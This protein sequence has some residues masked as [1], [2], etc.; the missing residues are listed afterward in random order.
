MLVDV[1]IKL[2]TCPGDTVKYSGTLAGM[3]DADEFA[4]TTAVESIVAHSDNV[5]EIRTCRVWLENGVV[6]S[7]AFVCAVAICV[8]IDLPSLL[9]GCFFQLLILIPMLMKLRCAVGDQP[10]ARFRNAC[11]ARSSMWDAGQACG[12]PD[13]KFPKLPP[14]LRGSLW[15]CARPQP[16]FVFRDV[17]SVVGLTPR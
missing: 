9:A 2:S 1:L 5:D 16:L 15:S 7:V 10:S 13:S 6:K 17:L 14:W 4:V 3:N 11:P 12:F 8:T